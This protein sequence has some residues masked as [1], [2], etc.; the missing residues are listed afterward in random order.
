MNV[1]RLQKE[2][3]YTEIKQ[4]T[5]VRIANGELN[6]GTRSFK[7]NETIDKDVNRT[8]FL[9]NNKENQ[10]KLKSLL[11]N[12]NK[13]DRN[14]NLNENKI[15]EELELEKIKSNRLQSELN[16]LKNIKETLNSKSLL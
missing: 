10:E 2:Y 4:N 13:H 7:N 15:H 1:K 8:I 12:I 16:R 5:K 14:E 6:K 11:I 3:N 9:S